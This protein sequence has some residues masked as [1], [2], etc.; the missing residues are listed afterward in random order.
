MVAVARVIST[1]VFARTFFPLSRHVGW[2]VKRSSIK[3]IGSNDNTYEL[4]DRVR[5]GVNVD[6]RRGAFA[7]HDGDASRRAR[8]DDDVVV[9]VGR[10]RER[11]IHFRRHEGDVSSPVSLRRITLRRAS[12]ACRRAVCPKWLAAKISVRERA[13]GRVTQIKAHPLT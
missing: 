4:G 8:R 10:E 11:H 13:S 3:D 5:R 6:R 7:T 12:H 1:R 9:A 2:S